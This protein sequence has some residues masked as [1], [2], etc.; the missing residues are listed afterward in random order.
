MAGLE[1]VGFKKRYLLAIIPLLIVGSIIYYFSDI[2]TYVILAWVL[3][4]V[5]APLT[6]FLKKYIGRNL[7]AVITLF[8]FI[9][10]FLLLIYIFIPPLLQ[11]ARNLAG[12]DYEGIADRLEEPISDWQKWLEDKGLMESATI[13]RSDSMVTEEIAEEPL[14]I[15]RT[16]KIDSLLSG[17]GDSLESS[18]VSLVINIQNPKPTEPNGS[19]TETVKSSDDFIDRVK[20][21]IYSYINPS[22]ISQI[23]SRIVGFLGN[24]VLA[25]MSVLFIA[26]F[27]LREQGLFNSA[28]S[29]VVSDKYEDQSSHALDETS[30]LLKRYFTGIFVQITIIT[31]FVSVSLSIIGVKNALLIGFF[32]ALM[33]VIPYIGPAIG[34]AFG[35][36]IT[37]ASFADPVLHPPEIDI[38]F[39]TD[40]LPTLVK[41]VVVFAIMQLLDNF[42]L[43]PTIFGKS[44]KAHPLEIFIIV[45]V[46]A[47]LGG[48]PGMVLAIPIY[49]VLRVVAKV[50]LSEFKVVQRITKS[51]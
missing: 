25:V 37:L 13:E 12:V 45:L 30:R 48:I 23:F 3:S 44:V 9:L 6:G 27:F 43:Q 15:S 40:I 36:I 10:G 29:S 5:G 22:Q 21:N 51:L 16:I 24:I 20:K 46:G 7:A 26:F 47:K 2:I 1:N 28:L 4:M 18:N 31:L 39:Y 42:I 8:T 19:A 34:A 11:Q 33:N 17:I 35:L 14:V 49:T 50:F 32:A 38:S 41:V